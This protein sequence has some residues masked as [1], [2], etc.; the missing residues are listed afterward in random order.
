VIVKETIVM[1]KLDIYVMSI[2]CCQ[3]V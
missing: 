1:I 2:G 3:E